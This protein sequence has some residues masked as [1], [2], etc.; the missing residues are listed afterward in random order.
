MTS[1]GMGLRK[2]TAMGTIVCGVDRSPGARAAVLTSVQLG[3]EFGVEVVAVHVEPSVQRGLDV[4]LGERAARTAGELVASVLT[5]D[6]DVAH[7]TVL[8][9]VGDAA[10]RL[11]WAAREHDASLIVLGA[12]TQGR[13][14]AF[15][16]SRLAA[17]LLDKAPVPVVVVPPELE[18]SGRSGR[19]PRKTTAMNTGKRFDHDGWLQAG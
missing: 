1:K 2:E 5:E 18:R 11:T 10:E 16:R 13:F 19:P 15:L 6:E 12:R 4:Y 17:E 7:V 9:S 3:R 14:R 8:G